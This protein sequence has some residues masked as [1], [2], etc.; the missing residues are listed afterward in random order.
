M[1]KDEAEVAL[2]IKDLVKENISVYEVK[3]EALSLEEAFINK[4]G[5]KKIV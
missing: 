2:F 1:I 3:K 4:A 5:G